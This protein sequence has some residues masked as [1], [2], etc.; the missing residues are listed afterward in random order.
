MQLLNAHY[1]TEE[2]ETHLKF[3][4]P[5]GCTFIYPLVSVTCLQM[6]TYEAML[7]VYAF[8]SIHLN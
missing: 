5:F 8:S 1:G 2:N 3:L 4:N 6:G 7:S